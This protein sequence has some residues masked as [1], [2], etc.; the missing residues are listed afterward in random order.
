MRAIVLARR[1]FRESNQV[2]TVYTPDKG[3]LELIARGL[4]KITA[5]NSAHLEPFSFVDIDTV[6]GKEYDYLTRVHPLEYFTDIRK[7]LDKS[8]VAQYLL[9]LVYRLLNIGESDKRVFDL[10]YS[11]FRFVDSI[12]IFKIILLDSF[13]MKFFALLGFQPALEACVICD[14]TYRSMM[15]ADIKGKHKPGFYFA[16]GGLVCEDC[17]LE[18]RKIGEQI[19]DCGIREVSDMQMILR[20]DWREV[21]SFEIDEVEYNKLHKLVYEFVIYHSEKKVGDWGEVL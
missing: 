9:N 5:K 11:W 7:D 10:L 21:A 12:D 6:P 14:R 13:V 3:K 17:K 4:K 16:G 20:G 8:L 18:K 15:K 1:D 2:I 19:V